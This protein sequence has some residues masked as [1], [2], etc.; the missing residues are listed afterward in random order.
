MREV[1][2]RDTN[3]VNF[4]VPSLLND[5]KNICLPKNQQSIHRIVT[6]VKDLRPDCCL[7]LNLSFFSRFQCRY[8]YLLV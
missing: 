8:F 5:W 1:G 7:S 2:E 4:D 6:L 3:T